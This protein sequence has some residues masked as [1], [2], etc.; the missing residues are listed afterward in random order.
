VS[1]KLKTDRIGVNNDDGGWKG[2]LR[3][4]HY[5][6]PLATVDYGNVVDATVPDGDLTLRVPFG[7]RRISY[8]KPVY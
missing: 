6:N 4:P 7:K 5:Y 2:C 1:V 8:P 3:K